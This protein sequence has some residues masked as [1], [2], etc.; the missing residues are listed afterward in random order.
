M[1]LEF[2]L[3]KDFFRGAYLLRVTWGKLMKIR[4]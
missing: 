2:L 4:R 3:G 1:A